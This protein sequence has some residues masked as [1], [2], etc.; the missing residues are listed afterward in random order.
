MKKVFYIISFAFAFIIAFSSDVKASTYQICDLV[1]GQLLHAGD[2]IEVIDD[3]DGYGYIQIERAVPL[4]NGSFMSNPSIGI[5]ISNGDSWEVP[6]NMYCHAPSRNMVSLS[7]LWVDLSSGYK[8]DGIER[9]VANVSGGVPPYTFYWIV[10]RR[11]PDGGNYVEPIDNTD[12]RAYICYPASQNDY[13]DVDIDD[14]YCAFCHVFDSYD[15]DITKCAYTMAF[16]QYIVIGN[17]PIIQEDNTAKENDDDTEKH[18][19]IEIENDN[20]ESPQ[21]P[22]TVPNGTVQVSLGID[23]KGY[24]NIKVLNPYLH[25]AVNQKI[26]ADLYAKNLKKHASV[27]MQK[28]LIPPYGVDGTWKN[29]S[30]TVK[31]KDLAVKKGDSIVIIWYTPKFGIHAPTLKYIPATVVEDGTIE[32]TIPAIGDMS[33]MSIVKLI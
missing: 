33:V 10:C 8:K 25:D 21:V 13:I 12:N 31:W 15:E 19:E 7:E 32:F 20:N 6:R 29:Q 24:A 9:I 23:G 5:H 30:H 11:A 27:L 26:L 18:T 17:V 4:D 14:A 3:I 2:T 1:E 28:N 16:Q 22:S